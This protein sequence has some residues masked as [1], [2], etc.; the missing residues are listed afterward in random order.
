MNAK[1]CLSARQPAGSSGRRRWHLTP[2]RLIEVRVIEQVE[3]LRPDTRHWPRSQCGIF[4][5]FMTRCQVRI[6][7]TTCGP[8]KALRPRLPKPASA[9]SVSN[10]DG[11]KQVWG[12][13]S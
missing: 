5:I 4:V 3:E 13:G 12:V 11:F 6:E 2:D 8:M 7:V 1:G 9:K 10:R